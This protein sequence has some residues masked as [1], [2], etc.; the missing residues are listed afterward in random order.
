M[1]R[2]GI[3]DEKIVAGRFTRRVTNRRSLCYFPAHGMSGDSGRGWRFFFGQTRR[4]NPR[5]FSARFVSGGV[6][7]LAFWLGMVV[8]LAAVAIWGPAVLW[9]AGGLSLIG[10]AL[11]VIQAQRAPIGFEDESGFHFGSP[12]SEAGEPQ[13]EGCGAELS[14]GD[15]A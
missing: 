7:I 2:A 4:R 9:I 14:P 5:G 11:L 13:G 6:E 10:F 3:P 12:D 8:A 1:A 15:C